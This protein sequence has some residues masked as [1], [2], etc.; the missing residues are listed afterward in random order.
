MLFSHFKA[1]LWKLNKPAL[2]SIFTSL[3]LQNWRGGE[4]R[5]RCSRI[6]E[7]INS[8][9]LLSFFPFLVKITKYT[10]HYILLHNVTKTNDVLTVFFFIRSKNQHHAEEIVP[11]KRTRGHNSEQCSAEIIILI[12]FLVLCLLKWCV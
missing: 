4:R 3:I 10:D 7:V 12:F 2:F 5:W 9:F 6:K 11:A 8:S 1:K